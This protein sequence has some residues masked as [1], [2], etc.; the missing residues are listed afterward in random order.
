MIKDEKDKQLE[1]ILYKVKM[2]ESKLD[3]VVK[4][5]ENEQ[6]KKNIDPIVQV[7]IGN[8]SIE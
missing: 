5:L 2:K 8:Q 7:V 4:Y 6:K 1:N 3:G